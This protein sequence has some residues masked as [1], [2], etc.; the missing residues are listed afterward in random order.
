[1]SRRLKRKGRTVTFSV[2]VDVGTKKL[3]RD[4]ADRSYRG[5][6]SELITQIAEQAA[7]Q[8]AAAEL[9]ALHGR[10]SMTDE[11]CEVFERALAVKLAAQSPGKRRKRRVA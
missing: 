11:E 5:N 3:L 6:V 1:M 8:E 2:S 4:V 10:P 7:R 9:L